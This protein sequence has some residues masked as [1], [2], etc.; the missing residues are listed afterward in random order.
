[1]SDGKKHSAVTQLQKE[2]TGLRGAK[3]NFASENSVMTACC[4]VLRLLRCG[5]AARAT[6]RHSRD[7]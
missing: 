1:M 6:L 4:L 5:G 7:S 2:E 3:Q